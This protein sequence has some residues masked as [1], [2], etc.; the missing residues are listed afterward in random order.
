VPNQRYIIYCDESDAKGRFYSNFYGGA[1]I[2]AED[3]AR[4]EAELQA[5]KDELN[6]FNGEM[7]WQKI[8]SNYKEKYITFL[9]A[10]FDIVAR[11]D[12]RL[13][14]M[15]THNQHVP[16]LQDYQIGKDYLMLYYQ[17]IKHAFGLRYCV[18]E[19]GTASAALLLDDMPSDQKSIDTFRGYLASLSDFPVWK[20][21]G[22]SIAYEDITNVDSKKHNIMQG[23]DIVLGG[24]CS[25]LNEKHTKPTPPL[26]RRGKTTHAK[27]DVYDVVKAR[28]KDVTHPHFNFGTSTRAEPLEQRFT[29]PYRHWCFI[30]S[31]STQ[32]PERT[33][34]AANKK[35]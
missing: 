27:S 21:A 25:R 29:H 14:I 10:Y 9:N 12:I 7:K 3:Q 26:K 20:N 23:L 5:I 1:I 16:K 34:K 18:P 2:R 22:F 30:P 35:K 31:N 15:F 13:R 32:D 33:K 8:T 19:G 4:I 17:F 24:V 6:I 11:G 28:V